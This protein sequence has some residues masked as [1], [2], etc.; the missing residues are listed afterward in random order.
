[1]S[2]VVVE[3]EPE[4]RD[5]V[6]HVLEDEGYHVISFSH[7]VPA[8]AL[9]GYEQRPRL[10]LIDIM[11]PEM[12]GIDLAERLQNVG[13]EDTPKIA[14]S[15]SQQCIRDARRSGLFRDTLDKPFEI[16]DLIDRVERHIGA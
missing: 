8:A 1:M 11:L 7:P 15:A 2:I 4:L 14:M 6:S 9:S 13:F 10:F 12:N 3:D 5:L 16:D